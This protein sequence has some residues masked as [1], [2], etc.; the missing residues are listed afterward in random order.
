MYT[1]TVRQRGQITIPG[2]IRRRQI[3]LS[4]GSIIHLIP[5][6]DQ[7]IIVRPYQGENIPKVDWK[8]IWDSIALARSLKGK[9]GN[10]SSFIINDR[11]TH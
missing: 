8:K 3:W 1:T 10:L 4:E 9:K 6:N 7:S 11:E 5:L 2:R